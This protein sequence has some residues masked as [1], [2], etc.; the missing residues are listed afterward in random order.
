MDL[1]ASGKSV[2]VGFGVAWVDDVCRHIACRRCEGVLGEPARSLIDAASMPSAPLFKRVLAASATYSEIPDTACNPTYACFLSY[3]S[4]TMGGGGA[5][6]QRRV[7]NKSEV[8]VAGLYKLVR[9]AG[10][11]SSVVDMKRVLSIFC[12]CTATTPRL[13]ARAWKESSAA[14]A[15]TAGQPSVPGSGSSGEAGPQRPLRGM[16]WEQ[17]SAALVWLAA[18][19][20]PVSPHGRLSN[21]VE[22]LVK[23]L[24]PRAVSVCSSR[25]P[26][27]GLIDVLLSPTCMS[28]L[29]TASEQ[30]HM[31]YDRITLV[32][33]GP[34]SVH[35]FLEFTRAWSVFPNMLSSHQVMQVFAQAA[36]VPIG[37]GRRAPTAAAG[38]QFPEFV[39]AIGRLALHVGGLP[40]ETMDEHSP[41]DKILHLLTTALGLNLAGESGSI[42]V[43][44]EATLESVYHDSHSTARGT[45]LPGELGAEQDQRRSRDGD[46]AANR[47]VREKLREMHDTLRAVSVSVDVLSR[48]RSDRPISEVQARRESEKWHG[49]QSRNAAAAAAAAAMRQRSAQPQAA[50]SA[51]GGDATTTAA[52]TQPVRRTGSTQDRPRSTFAGPARGAAPVDWGARGQGKGRVMVPGSGKLA[53]HSHSF[54][55]ARPRTATHVAARSASAGGAAAAAA[56]GT[57]HGREVVGG[58]A[59]ARRTSALARQQ[60]RMLVAGH[61]PLCLIFEVLYAPDC[62]YLEVRTTRG[63]IATTWLLGLQRLP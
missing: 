34:L 59:V 53:P 3:Q 13:V 32:D 4:A 10:L 38:L 49:L 28:A 47:L 7:G 22:H 25:G 12:A 43:A 8:G 29:V 17:F 42:G 60:A 11:L 27:D 62:P 40:Q 51:G 31:I 55:D 21:R 30:L 57:H 37:G 18:Y 23:H 9:D 46:D 19:A 35:Q 58:G 5:A 14:A 48:P 39:E 56:R 16:R 61:D 45:V 6:G 52:A 24:V 36:L 15:A 1:A 54:V 63:I 33:G 2:G 44:M 41:A 20:V 26:D 50:A